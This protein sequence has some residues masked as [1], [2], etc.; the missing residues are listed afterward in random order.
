VLAFT[1]VNVVSRT[2]RVPGNNGGVP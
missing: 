1:V 2:V